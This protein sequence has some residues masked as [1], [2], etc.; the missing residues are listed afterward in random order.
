MGDLLLLSSTLPV[1]GDVVDGKYRIE[2]VLGAGGMGVVFLATHLAVENQIALKFL[3]LGTETSEVDQ[4]RFL[5]EARAAGKLNSAHVV[6]VY[7]A[8]TTLQGLPYI[9]MEYFQ[10][11]DLSEILESPD[12]IEISAA[13]EFVAQAAAG[14][15][16]AHAA[17]I[18]HR[19]V[20]PQNIVVGKLPNGST[21]VKVL[22]FGIAK[23]LGALTQGLTASNIMVGSPLYMSPEQMRGQPAD[24]RVDIWALGIILYEL[25]ARQHPFAAETFPELCL[26]VTSMDPQ[27]LQDLA[28]KVPR[29]LADAVM[30]C[31]ARDREARFET[32]AAFARAIAPF[33][34]TSRPVSGGLHTT[35]DLISISSGSIKAPEQVLATTHGDG[36]EPSK[37]FGL[38]S[39][40]LAFAF[41]VLG[42]TAGI[43]LSLNRNL[44][45]PLASTLPTS[46]LASVAAVASP[47]ASE[48]S[49]PS[50]GV[51]IESLPSTTAIR[52][53]GSAP[54][55]IAT[56]IPKQSASV[57]S[58]ASIA[59]AVATVPLPPPVPTAGHNGAAVLSPFP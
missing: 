29:T 30:R 56:V 52:S 44:A 43:S 39:L 45:P 7:D 31:L 33:A 40:T 16:D 57:R 27:P 59:T 3:K 34:Q 22:D 21:I 14:I 58:I 26:R 13:V 12:V 9:A 46:G 15:L 2:R 8:G 41:G 4:S 37:R 17:G 28:P 53:H 19:D 32:V 10:G 24:A 50:T 42:L 47:F 36:H 23:S 18:V 25:L 51:S 55:P 35:D 54:H 48:P 1:V 49:P 20:K 5:H 11:R 38:R 6:R